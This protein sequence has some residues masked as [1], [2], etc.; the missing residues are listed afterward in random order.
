MGQTAQRI[1]LRL[2]CAD[3]RHHLAALSARDPQSI[4]QGALTYQLRRLRLHGL[5]ERLPNSLRYRVTEFGWRAALFFTRL[6]NRLPRPGL[7]AVLP[8]RRAIDAPLKR[9][10]D[11]L[12]TQ[13]NAWINQAKLP[14]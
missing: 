2:R 4:W 14:V 13:V 6:Y 9:A 8:G 3:L 11:N 5:I 10:F 12:D 1:S 7:A